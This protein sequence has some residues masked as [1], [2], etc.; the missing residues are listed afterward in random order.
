MCASKAKRIVDFKDKRVLDLGCG[1]GKQVIES[2]GF[3]IGID[4]DKEALLSAKAKGLNVFL[5]DLEQGILPFRDN[6]FDVVIA[7]DIL[8]H[9][10][11]HVIVVKEAYRTLKNDGYLIVHVPSEYS[12]FIWAD[13]THKRAY[14]ENS[15]RSLMKDNG[16]TMISFGKDRKMAFTKSLRKNIK[17]LTVYFT[18]KIIWLLTGV[19]LN[20]D[21]YGVIAKDRY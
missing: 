18:F 4:I 16:F 10:H 12:Q 14:T 7:V 5:F 20:V 1:R 6:A 2:L 8:E 21:G 19:D 15:I 11:S 17:L 13:Y 9:L 3:Y